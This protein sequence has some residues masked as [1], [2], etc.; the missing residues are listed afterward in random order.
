ME[1]LYTAQGPYTSTAPIPDK[2][3]ST[4]P[5]RMNSGK[6]SETISPMEAAECAMSKKH[7]RT[8]L[9]EDIKMTGG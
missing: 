7:K 3:T 2:E 5:S 8:R 1:A 9:R 6:D 4:G